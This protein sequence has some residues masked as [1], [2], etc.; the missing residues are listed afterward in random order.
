LIAPSL[1]ATLFLT[2]LFAVM[3]PA[4][5]QASAAAPAKPHSAAAVNSSLMACLSDSLL[6][7]DMAR[8]PLP[9]QEARQE[10]MSK[11]APL[12]D[13]YTDLAASLFDLH[14]ATGEKFNKFLFA[15]KVLMKCMLKRGMPL[16]GDI[17][18]SV[19]PSCFLQSDVIY[20]AF[21][22]RAAG[23]TQAEAVAVLEK[24]FPA[25]LLSRPD[26]ITATVALVY[27]KPN[28][29]AEQLGGRSSFVKS[30][31]VEAS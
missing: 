8:T 24:V 1:T 5:G 21:N 22:Y 18:P 29:P 9:T 19:A 15:E 25:K 7:L 30:C 3:Q 6:G 4:H 20:H 11:M 14:D 27:S 31:L 23:K 13:R 10:L 26:F 16:E 17:A 28:T 12:G 2:L